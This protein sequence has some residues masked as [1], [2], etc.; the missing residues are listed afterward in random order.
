MEIINFKKLHKD[1]VTPFYATDGSNAMDLTAIK[2]EY[3]EYGTAIK[4]YFGLAFEIP[5]GKV[6]LIFPR[7]SIYKTDLT[8]SN[9]VGV[10][11]SDYRGEITAIFKIFDTGYTTYKVG[12]RV[13]QIMFI[14]APQINLK[15][16]TELT[17]TDRGTGGYGSTG[18]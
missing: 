6:G 1:A 8:L 7:S 16:V 9:A 11:D 3:V 2:E 13:A 12:D 17:P 5:K 4:Y 14:D 15:E 10:I 18:K